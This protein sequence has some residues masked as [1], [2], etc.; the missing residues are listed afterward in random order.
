[1]L[2]RTPRE[3]F[4]LLSTPA[5]FVVLSVT[6][7]RD[8][9]GSAVP[10]AHLLMAGGIAMMIAQST[11]MTLPQALATER[12]DGTLL[13]LKTVPGGMTAFLV[14]KTVVVLVTAL[15]GAL[16]TL[17]LGA[18]VAGT[19]LP[20]DPGHWLT[21]GWVLLLGLLALVPLGAMIGALL[22]NPREALGFT[23][24]PVFALIGTSGLFFPVSSLPVA[25]QN[26]V[27]IFPVKWL[28]QGVR[29]ALLPDAAL[30]AEP[31][32]SWQHMETFAVLGAWAVVGFVLAPR[33]LRNMTRRESGSRPMKT[34]VQ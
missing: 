7:D 25:V 14:G 10:M 11:L 29:S 17:V 32:Q 30:A 6:T 18:L 28:A 19:D 9:A 1:M 27:E 8:I 2:L 12:E 4:S 16:V 31:A 20:P 34:E 23:L 21:L 5:L 33:L 3:I 22:P 13:R 15:G 26:V 24:I